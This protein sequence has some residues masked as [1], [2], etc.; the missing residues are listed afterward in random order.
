MSVLV[1]TVQQMHMDALTCTQAVDDLLLGKDTAAA[2]R[3]FQKAKPAIEEA[4]EKWSDYAIQTYYAKVEGALIEGSD[5]DT[6]PGLPA[7][8]IYA[9]HWHDLALNVALEMA[10]T[11]KPT[12]TL[13][14]QVKRDWPGEGYYRARLTR[15]AYRAMRILQVDEMPR[16]PRLE[17]NNWL[18]SLKRRNPRLSPGE[19][20][21]MQSTSCDFLTEW[22]P[23]G[24][25]MIRKIWSSRGLTGQRGKRRF[26]R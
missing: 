25:E 14:Q 8:G 10:A 24:H 12:K 20:E 23:V 11:S 22:E 16:N 18:C 13:M 6:L 1:R 21:D 3:V 7:A 26:V 2:I 4:S 19:A 17:R 15:E 5:T 9:A